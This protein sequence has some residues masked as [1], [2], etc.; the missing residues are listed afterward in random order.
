MSSI[1]LYLNAIFDTDLRVACC[2]LR[3]A[4]CVLRVACCV[5]RVACKGLLKLGGFETKDKFIG[6]FFTFLNIK[7]KVMIFV[8]HVLGCPSK[9]YAA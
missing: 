1:H 8:A 2:V 6:M 4:C 7:L 9:S 5:L 3:V